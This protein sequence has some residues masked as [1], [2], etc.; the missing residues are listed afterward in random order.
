MPDCVWA[1]VAKDELK[2]IKDSRWDL[3]SI[4]QSWRVRHQSL[5]TSRRASAVSQS[6]TVFP[7]TSRSCLVC[8]YIPYFEFAAA[9]TLSQRTLTSLKT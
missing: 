6:T 5:T 7:H 3:V 9:L 1:I 2:D 4:K 8:I